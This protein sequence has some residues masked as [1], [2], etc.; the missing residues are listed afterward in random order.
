MKLRNCKTAPIFNGWHLLHAGCQNK[1]S[2]ATLRLQKLERTG[3]KGGAQTFWKDSWKVRPMA[4]ASPTLFIWVV[5]SALAP[6]NFSNAKRGICRQQLCNITLSFFATFPQDAC[7]AKVKPKQMQK[8]LMALGNVSN[9]KR[10]ICRQQPSLT[11]SRLPPF[12]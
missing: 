9:A 8:Q 2:R 10:G 11:P 7:Q 1:W 12:R 5:S 4:M 6:G 3:S